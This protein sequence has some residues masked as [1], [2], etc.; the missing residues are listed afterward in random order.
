MNEKKSHLPFIILTIDLIL[1]L[2]LPI[3]AQKSMFFDGITYATVARNL[4]N[5]EGTF[6]FL[7]YTDS[8]DAQFHI[9]P[10]LAMG[11]LSLFYRIWGDNFYVERVYSL[12]M[13][14]ISAFL[15]AKIWQKTFEKD[16]NYRQFWWLPVLFWG[17]SPV[18]S[19]SYRNNMLENT[20]S[21]FSL[22]SVLS[23]LYSIDI[24][25]NKK[26]FW[27]FLAALGMFAGALSK[28]LVALFP[29]ATIG[30]YY[31]TQNSETKKM[32]F[33][34]MLFTSLTL[35]IGFC[36]L[37]LLLF[38]LLPDAAKS[39]SLY[40][41]KVKMMLNEKTVSSHFYIL[42]R[43]WQEILPAIIAFLL[44]FFLYLRQK[45]GFSAIKNNVPIA[46]FFLLIGFSASLP[47]MVSL[48]QSNYYLLPSIP[49]FSLTFSV[50]SVPILSHFWKKITE[51][52]RNFALIFSIIMGIGVLGF[53]A[54]QMG[55]IGKDAEVIADAQAL[56]KFFPK[57]TIIKTCYQLE[58]DF[59]LRAYLARYHSLSLNSDIYHELPKF[60]LLP[61]NEGCAVIGMEMYAEVPLEMKVYK[62]Y[63]LKE[64]M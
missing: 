45:I 59:R 58:Y 38:K 11:I 52:T 36:V 1:A 63:K 34:Q 35:L 33:A 20:V 18:V 17:I 26:Y 31:F 61:A 21:V 7:H 29:L 16:E 46:L 19:W 4:A 47:I 57:H 14:A 22:F 62:L 8:F 10:P 64:K 50:L 39:L 37:F 12:L 40:Q 32:T 48:R 55:K 5:G 13:A 42:N 54:A 9:Q 2:L 27:L 53:S 28:G 56:A 15:I 49:Y 25:G 43:L 30:I 41:E 60:V 44:L 24:Q 6:W 51:K 23:I 3:M